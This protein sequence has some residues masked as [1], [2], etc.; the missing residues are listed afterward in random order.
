MVYRTRENVKFGLVRE[1]SK[2]QPLQEIIREVGRV[3]L[4]HDCG[5]QQQLR[6][7]ELAI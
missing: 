3:A 1:I 5:P 6:P 2:P 7:K 4:D